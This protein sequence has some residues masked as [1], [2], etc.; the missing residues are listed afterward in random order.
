MIV[1]LCLSEHSAK[2][3]IKYRK[4]SI[5]QINPSNNEV[6]ATFVSVCDAEE[7]GFNTSN[8]MLYNQEQNTP[9]Y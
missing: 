3:I 2:N 1:L 6:V 5:Q 4:V 7:Y 8:I 9:S